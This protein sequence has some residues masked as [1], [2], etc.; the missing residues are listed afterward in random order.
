MHVPTW[1]L[2]GVSW[3]GGDGGHPAI[4]ASRTLS[5][6]PVGDR[7]RAPSWPIV[8][9]GVLR[10]PDLQ[11]SLA[12]L[13]FVCEI[14]QPVRV[15]GC[16]GGALLDAPKGCRGVVFAMGLGVSRGRRKRESL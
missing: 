16:R 8:G 13:N 7:Q 4:G 5:F 9:L 3:L 12:H 6:P 11:L 2:A 15:P 1:H 10:V 14:L